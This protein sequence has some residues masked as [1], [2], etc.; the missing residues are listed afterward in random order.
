MGEDEILDPL[1]TVRQ[2]ETQMIRL[3]LGRLLAVCAVLIFISGCTIPQIIVMK[4]PL[5]PEEHIN[6]GMA[7]EQKKEYSLA[8]KEYEAAAKNLK[9]ARLYLAN[10]RF[11]NHQPDEAESLYREILRDN[12]NPDAYNNLAWLL[13]TRKKDLSEARDLALKAIELKPQER[14]YRDTLDKI[15]RAL[16]QS[17]TP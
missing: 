17:V 14:E 3:S 7:Y 15:E 8:I 12:P 9:T 11:L 13:Y 6:L 1:D 5:T 2:T 10:A 4:D 16:K